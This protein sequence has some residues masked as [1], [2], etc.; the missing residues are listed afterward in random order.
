MLTSTPVATRLLPALLLAGGALIA[1]FR[2]P[3]HVDATSSATITC[4][5]TGTSWE[6][7]TSA[8]FFFFTPSESGMADVP[9]WLVNTGDRPGAPV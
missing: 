2:T 3:A 4:E 8:T 5:A 7:V 1:V 9:F 6:K